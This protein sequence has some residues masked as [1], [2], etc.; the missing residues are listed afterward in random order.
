M[1]ER[2]AAGVGGERNGRRRTTPRGASTATLPAALAALANRRCGARASPVTTDS[3]PEPAPRGLLEDGGPLVRQR[4]HPWLQAAV[5][6]D[7]PGDSST[8]A[9]KPKGSCRPPDRDPPRKPHRGTLREAT[10]T[11]TTR[12]VPRA[13][14]S[15]G[16]AAARGRAGRGSVRTVNGYSG[17]CRRERHLPVGAVELAIR[18]VP[19]ASE[20]RNGANRGPWRRR[21]RESRPPADRETARWAHERHARVRPRTTRTPRCPLPEDGRRAQQFRDRYPHRG[22]A[23]I[24]WT[25]QAPETSKLTTRSTGR[26]QDG[27]RWAVGRSPCGA[28]VQLRVDREAVGRNPRTASASESNHDDARADG[29]GVAARPPAPEQRGPPSKACPTDPSAGSRRGPASTR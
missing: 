1:A 27:C 8:D 15:S 9:R 4:P 19:R 11:T 10:C 5:V 16:R 22:G 25:W 14:T 7:R 29:A 12:G 3:S 28:H 17:E 18:V 26:W 24:Q 6:P 2:G 13:T 21:G 20:R 23:P